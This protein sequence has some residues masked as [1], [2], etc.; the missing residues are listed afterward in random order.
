MV[1]STSQHAGT[2]G[3]GALRPPPPGNTT[4][5]YLT[6]AGVGF[7]YEEQDILGDIDISV[8][9]RE[10]V[11]LIGPSGCGKSTLLN[12]ASGVLA[13]DSGRIE[14]VDTPSDNR[15]E[16]RLGHVSYMQQKDLLLPW[17]TVSENARLGLEL[18]GVNIG[19]TDLLVNRLA[20]SFGL[21]GVLD[22]M[23][24]Q[25][26]G[27]MRQR[28]ALLRALLPDN[29]VLLLDEPFGAL[30][31]ITRSGLQQWLL[32]VLDRSNRAV[33][34]VTHDVEEAIILADRV[35]VMAPGPGRI[36]AE[37]AIDLDP[38]VP[39]NLEMTTSGD[40]VEI[41]KHLLSLLRQQAVE[42]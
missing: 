5:A 18:R 6:I 3:G 38:D 13:P 10:F 7:R 17:R 9:R 29:P 20:E 30:D 42:R 36:I 26:S 40:F 22:M 25:L 11:A 2:A 24:W 32:N 8:G 39:R 23:P 31:A 35:L 16:S 41:K 34:L 33:L 4:D 19:E 1:G 28:V 15:P 14:V 12:L 27:G 21:S 37:V